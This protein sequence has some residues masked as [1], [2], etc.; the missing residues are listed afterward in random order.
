MITEV[1]RKQ[2][3]QAQTFALFGHQNIDGDALGSL[4]GLGLQLEKLGKTVFYFTTDE[5]SPLF[6]FLDISTLQH[7]FDYG[8]YD[9][10]VFL[11]FT[12]YS[13]ISKFTK[14]NEEY[15]DQQKKIIIDH[16]LFDQDLPNAT[17]YR[18]DTAIATCELVYELTTQWWEQAQLFDQR[19]ATFLYMGMI[20]DSGNFRH[21]EKHQTLRLME[22]A[23]GVI[24]HGADKQAVI[25]NLFRNKSYEDLQ[26]MQ[27]ILGRMLR[28]GDIFYSRYGQEEL[29]EYGLHRD[30]ADYALYLMVDVK[31]AE[32]ILLGKETEEGIRFS[33]RGKGKYNCREIAG[34]F[35]G[36]GHFN[37]S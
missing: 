24:K 5:P 30:S 1:I 2:F 29:A 25:N 3:E 14:G 37:A 26:F 12:E 15:F 35:G 17:I 28:D 33:L 19:I 27:K 9:F 21:D 32:L 31:E 4:Y 18:D 22:D 36:G 23:L 16:H 8:N 11:D 13:R 7:S 6:S 20:S 10:L 34:K